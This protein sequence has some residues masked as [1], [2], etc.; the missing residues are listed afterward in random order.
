MVYSSQGLNNVAKKLSISKTTAQTFFQSFYGR[1]RKVKIW[2]D[3]VKDFAREHKYVTT[4]TG[5]RR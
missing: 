3:S 5:R 1:F 4:I 2:M